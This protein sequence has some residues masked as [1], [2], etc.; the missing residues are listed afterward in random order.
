ESPCIF[1]ANEERLGIDGSRRDRILRTLVRNLFD[2]HQQSIFLT[3][4]NEYTD[5]SR[6][7]EQPINILESMADILS[8][9]LVVSPL[10]QTGDLHSGPPLTSSIAGAVDTTAGAGKTFFYIFTHQHPCVVTDI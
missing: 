7:V 8:D 9:S 1:S 4:I 2:F 6:A 5:W 3:L 10:I